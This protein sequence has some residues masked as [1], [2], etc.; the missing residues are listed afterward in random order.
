MYM[1][2][3]MAD[4]LIILFLISIILTSAES[5]ETYPWRPTF[6]FVPNPLNWMNDPSGP[7]YDA[8]TGIYHLFFE[9]QSPANWGHCISRDMLNWINLPIAVKND[10]PYDINGVYTGSATIVNNEPIL[11]HSA[12]MVNNEP[13]LMC[14][15]YP[16]NTNDINLTVWTEYSGNCVLNSSRDGNPNGRDPTT[17]WTTDNGKTWTFAYALQGPGSNGAAIT[18][19]TN[20]WKQW[21]RAPKYL[22][23]SNNSGGWECPDFFILPKSQQF[24]GITHVMKVSFAKDGIGRD[25]WALGGYNNETTEFIPFNNQTHNEAWSCDDCLWDVGILYASKTFYDSKNDR[26]IMYGWIVEVGR[27]IPCTYNPPPPPGVWCGVQA[28][29]REI[30]LLSAKDSPTNKPQILSY[31]IPEFNTLR[32]ENTKYEINDTIILEPGQIILFD[33]DKIGG[34]T[35]DINLKWQFGSSGDC[36]IWILCDK[37]GTNK[38]RVGVNFNN[39]PNPKTFYIDNGG[40]T[41]RSR[42]QHS[43]TGWN[44]NDSITLR[45]IVDHSVISVFINNGITVGTTRYYPNYTDFR[46]GVAMNDQNENE[47]SN[48]CILS[49]FIAYNVTAV[50]QPPN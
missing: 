34:N 8:N 21:K 45:V 29:P 7:F 4:Q 44:G 19:Q 20:D 28:L 40:N 15:V 32:I 38:T 3:V 27:P 42:I 39:V 23:Y 2:M 48:K 9:Y 43:V 22:S 33:S 37:N 46:V 30:K 31:P 5:S 17:S 12:T 36:S 35:M 18:Y 10:E 47:Q 14:I 26:Q 11:M 41:T 50:T 1:Y 6:H 49:S 16:N 25:W 13:I 24:D